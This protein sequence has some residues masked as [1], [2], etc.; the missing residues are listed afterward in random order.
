MIN[1]IYSTTELRDARQCDRNTRSCAA[2]EDDK[3]FQHGSLELASATAK[4]RCGGGNNSH[5]VAT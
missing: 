4:W 1:Q 3:R 2:V 5:Y